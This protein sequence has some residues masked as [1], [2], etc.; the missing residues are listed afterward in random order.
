[1]ENFERNAATH[2]PNFKRDRRRDQQMAGFEGELAEIQEKIARL[3]QVRKDIKLSK[4][5][6]T[7]IE[8]G[9]EALEKLQAAEASV[10][11]LVDE[12][13]ILF[14]RRRELKV[15]IGQAKSDTG[16]ALGSTE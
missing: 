1:M 9:E 16:A 12:N 6:L 14:A 4:E 3:E 13:S 15:L 5:A 2:D 10:Q 8:D 11:A 7:D